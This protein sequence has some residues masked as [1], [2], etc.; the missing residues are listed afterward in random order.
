MVLVCRNSEREDFNGSRMGEVVVE[1]HVRGIGSRAFKQSIVSCV[2]RRNPLVDGR[3][4]V[5]EGEG[6]GLD[7]GRESEWAVVTVA[8]RASC[9]D[10]ISYPR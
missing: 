7:R 4:T 10:D 9:N 5:S 1:C 3:V 8:P 6:D 2:P